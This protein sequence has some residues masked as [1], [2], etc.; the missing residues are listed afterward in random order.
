MNV[1]RMR[2]LKVILFIY[3]FSNANNENAS[4]SEVEGTLTALKEV[5]EILIL[6]YYIFEKTCKF[7]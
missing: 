1:K 5:T 3:T 6:T 2:P 4:N 7:S